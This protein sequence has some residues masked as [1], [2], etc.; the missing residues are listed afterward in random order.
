MKRD[1][2]QIK[3]FLLD[4]D[5]TL[6]LG[7]QIFEGTI[8]FL[9]TLKRRGKKRLFLTNN[10][11]T[12]ASG[13]RKR[14]S[15]IG[16]TTESGEVFT[17]AIATIIYLNGKNAGKRLYLLAT[18]PVEEEFV[19]AGFELTEENPDYVVLA[20]DK[21]LRYE[22]LEKACRFLLEGIPFIATHPDIVCPTEDLP[23]PD[24][25][26]I[27]KA[28]IAATNIEPKVIGKP[29]KEMITSA[30][31]ELDALP[32]KTAIVGDRLYTD[33]EMG[34]RSGLTTILVLSGETKI[35]DVNKASQKP[36]YILS[37]VRELA[38]L[39]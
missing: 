30:L 9:N 5:G 4:M 36:D 22:K 2:R 18:P 21:T 27:T 1:I 33:M 7:N 24:C 12:S 13:Y 31:A 20:F 8:D 29:N 15:R 35:E 17:S 37:S 6:Y 11:S 26:A 25:G 28:I 34:F 19:Q 14:L 16:I 32:S 23:I 3:N 39:I 38:G 10:S